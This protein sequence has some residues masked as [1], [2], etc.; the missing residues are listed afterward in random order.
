ML[1]SQI[2]LV[3]QGNICTFVL[4]ELRSGAL[5]TLKTNETNKQTKKTPGRPVLLKLPK[6]FHTAS[7][8]AHLKKSLS[9]TDMKNSFPQ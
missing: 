4:E 2:S 5:K 9:G 7:V 6:I 8:T 1:V 3:S